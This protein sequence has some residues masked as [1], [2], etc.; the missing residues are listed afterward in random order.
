MSTMA[1]NPTLMLEW[2]WEERWDTKSTAGCLFLQFT[3]DYFLTLSA[4]ILQNATPPTPKNLE[5]AMELWTLPSL[6]RL[7]KDVYLKPFNHA[8]VENVP[9]RRNPSFKATIHLFFPDPELNI[10]ECSVWHPFLIKGYIREF[11]ETIYPIT[12]KDSAFLLQNLGK[13][14]GRVQCL[15]NAVAC[16]TKAC[17]RLWEQFEGDVQMLTNLIFYKI[18]RVGKAKRMNI[19]RRKWAKA[20]KA[21]IEARLDEQHS[22]IPFNEGRL[23]T[24]Q[25]RK[26]CKHE[27]KRRLGKKNNYRKPP[28]KR[29]KMPEPPSEESTSDEAH[30]SSDEDEDVPDVPSALV[31][32]KRRIFLLEVKSVAPDEE[33]QMHEENEDEEDQVD[34]SDGDEDESPMDVDLHF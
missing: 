17:G 12:E 5:E 29:Q 26:A 32:R 15:P 3:I 25:V 13:I 22:N 31:L 11:H 23:K 16:T 7:L 28:V 33:D 21:I 24:R 34:E 4:D 2:V 19:A 14:F 1:G 9:G 8:L 18:E 20:S 10:W 30:K 27:V 6:M